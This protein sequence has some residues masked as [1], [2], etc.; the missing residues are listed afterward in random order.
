MISEVFVRHE[1]EALPA[2]ELI[3]AASKISKLMNVC[4]FWYCVVSE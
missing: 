2:L 4:L 1:H 3:C